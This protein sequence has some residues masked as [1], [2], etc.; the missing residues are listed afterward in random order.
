MYAFK[1]KIHGD[2][3]DSKE[4][5]LSGKGVGNLVLKTVVWCYLMLKFVFVLFFA[6]DYIISC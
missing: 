4:R 3:A 1:L 6:S 5:K 2:K